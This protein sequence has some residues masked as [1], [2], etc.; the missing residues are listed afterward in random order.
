MIEMPDIWNAPALL[1]SNFPSLG[2]KKQGKVR[3]TYDLGDCLL[4]VA[5]D[6]ISAFDVVLTEGIPGKGY[7]LTQLSRCWFERLWKKDGL[8]PHHLRT[9]DPGKF[10]EACQPYLE[11][12]AGRSMVVE[13]AHPLPVECIVRGYL[14]GSAWNEY[15]KQGTVCEQPLPTGL[16]ESDPFAEPLF[17]PST[18]AT[19]GHDENISFDKMKA[20]IGSALA[21]EVKRVSF[22]IYKRAAALAEGRG[23]I[24]ADT[25][26]E[27]GIDSQTKQLMVIDE[28]LTP[29]SS[30]FWPKD[31][32]E[33]G[34]S[35]PSF[36]KQYVRDYLDSVGWDH[37]PPPPHLPDEVVKQTSAKY[38]EALERFV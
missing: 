23:I 30:R 28:V 37:S 38:R 19:K 33:A 16:R 13:K 32:Y 18:K 20:M 8:V 34:K 3:D 22:E 15:K 35:Q 5:S 10:P 4:L 21:E 17:T 24:I 26:F 7:V 31:Q 1:E 25:K 11:I 27:F 9:M 12:L 2:P 6:R 14:S 29:D 36:D